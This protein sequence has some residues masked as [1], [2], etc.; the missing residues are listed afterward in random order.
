MII[1]LRKEFEILGIK[2]L[3]YTLL[4]IFMEQIGSHRK[5]RA[6]LLQC[7]RLQKMQMSISQK[8]EKH[9]RIYLSLIQEA[10]AAPYQF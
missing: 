3:N 5:I 10:S 1:V 9:L 7:F 8:C 2:V 4:H 6:Q